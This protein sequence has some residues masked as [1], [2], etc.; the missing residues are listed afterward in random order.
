MLNHQKVPGIGPVLSQRLFDWRDKIAS[1]F[2]PRQGLPE[3]EK[4]RVANRY[5][6]VLLPLGQALQSA[7]ND[8]EAITVSHRASEAERIKAI[9]AAV[10]N[11]A[12]AEAY[13]RAMKVV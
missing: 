1:S 11:L 3:S 6:P 4:I 12:V 9:A 10:Q 8:L 5:A 7:I 13:I 2:R